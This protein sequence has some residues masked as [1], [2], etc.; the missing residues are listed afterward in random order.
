MTDARHERIL[1][2]GSGIAGLGAALAL[3][4]GGRDVTILDRDPAPPDLSAE[5]A[6]YSWERKG[7]TQLRH[8]H[9]FLG[10]LTSLIRDKY[11]ELLEQL[12]AAGARV[13]P[14]KDG[15]PPALRAQYIPEPGDDDLSIL[16]SRRTTLE[17][18]MRRYAATLPGVTFVSDAGVRGILSHREG[19]F[20]VVDGLNV[21]R[22]GAVHDMRA[23]IVVDA[24]GRNTSMPDWLRAEGVVVSEE[25]APCGILYYTRHYK[26]RDGQDEPSREGAPGAGALGYLG[27]GVFMA[28]NRHFSI[29][30]AVPEIENEL[31]MAVMKP[32]TFDTICSEIP[33]AARWI[34][35]VRAEPVSQVFSMGNLK[36][37]WR[38]W[39]KDHEP[40]V[41]NFFAIGDAAVRTNPLYG[42]GCSAG[43]VHA[44]VLRDVL[45]TTKNARARARI[46]E[47]RTRETLRPFYD[48]MVQQDAQAIRRAANERDPN[49]KPSFRARLTKGFI[50]DAVQP[51]TRS[52]VGLLR[53]FSR[54][55]HMIDKPTDW[56]KSPSN[57]AKLLAIWATTKKVKEQ[58][59][60]YAPKAG[61]ERAE[62]FA[63]LHIAA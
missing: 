62:M 4:G 8:S 19:E 30:L 9:V 7:A 59:K 58:R 2:A 16:F 45:D 13:F 11:P 53:D 35:P 49:Y 33:G 20:L 61:P 10:R 48:S 43:V 55:F 46:I 22:D 39:Q 1:V 18:V 32:E 63:K 27:F 31:R 57:V 42:R 21:E 23:D 3:S 25:E 37:V 12:K 36:S 54:A 24:T 14:F 40:Q 6:F 38:S 15:L 28:D 60:L 29:T 44:H 50:E 52:D 34:D 56:L 47:S 26:L 17:L 5:E 51:A 41:L